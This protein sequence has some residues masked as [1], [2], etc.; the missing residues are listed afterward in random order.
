MIYHLSNKQGFLSEIRRILKPGGVFFAST[1][2]FN[3]LREIGEMLSNY[4]PDLEWWGG[5]SRSFGLENGREQLAIW[6]D[7]ITCDRYED[8][9]NVTDVDLLADYV[10][11]GF[12]DLG[13]EEKSAYRCSVV[14]VLE[15][16]HG[17]LHITKEGGLFMAK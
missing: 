9:L 8:A 17:S 14:D 7:D 12:V 10:L 2:G 11:S 5:T 15:S 4:S 6:F 3:H 13:E 1:N 16:V